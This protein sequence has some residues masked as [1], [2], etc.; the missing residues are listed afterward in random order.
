MNLS[1][2]TL[3][4]SIIISIVIVSFIVGYFTLML[5]SLY[6]DHIQTQNYDSV[7]AVQ[8]NYIQKRSYAATKVLNPTTTFTLELPKTGYR[9]YLAASLFHITIDVTDKE[10]QSAI[11]KAREYAKDPKKINLLKKDEFDFTKIKEKLIPNELFKENFSFNIYADTSDVKN[12]YTVTSEKLHILSDDLI[13]FEANITDATN[14]Y[15][16]F[17]AFGEDDTSYIITFAPTMTPSMEEIKPVLLRS[18]PMIAAIAFLLALL[19]SQ[20]FSR[21]IVGPIVRLA[22]HAA[23]VD[24]IHD[25]KLPPIPVKGHDEIASLGEI[26]NQLY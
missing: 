17:L 21:L 10:L 16:S 26:L 14:Y 6:V 25:S 7:V 13:V 3:L 8:K 15:T 9:I 24:L 18:L 12:P 22:D 23:S 19:L 20:L 4:Y 2:K 1:K 5:P 11:D